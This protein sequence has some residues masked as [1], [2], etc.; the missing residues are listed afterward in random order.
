MTEPQIP[1]EFHVPAKRTLLEATGVAAL[2]AGI[3]LLLFILPAEYGVDP[4][5]FGDAIG[6]TGMAAPSG[7]GPSVH[8]IEES[9]YRSDTVDVIIPAGRGLEYKFFLGQGSGLVYSWNAT[10]SLFF[11]FHGEPQGDTTGYFESYATGTATAADGSFSAP[12]GGTHGWYW[13]NDASTAVTVTL[14]TAG[15]YAIVG[16]R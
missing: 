3:I 10:G 13:R 4:T 11:D 2:M 16:I 6:I 14:D 1:D 9:H 5:G 12:F 7:S 8:G 15:H